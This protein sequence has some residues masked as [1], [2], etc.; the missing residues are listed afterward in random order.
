[1]VQFRQVIV[2]VLSIVCI[3]VNQ[4]EDISWKSSSRAENQLSKKG[5]V[6]NEWQVLLD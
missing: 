1:M 2:L 4:P 5:R 3:Q 6:P